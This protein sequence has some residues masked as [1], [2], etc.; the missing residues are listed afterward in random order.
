M[1]LDPEVVG[2]EHYEVAAQVQHVLQRY[3]ELQDI[4]SVLGMDELSDDEKLIV[5]RARKIQFFLVTKLLCC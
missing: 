5:A 1:P 2:E 3:Q 4:I